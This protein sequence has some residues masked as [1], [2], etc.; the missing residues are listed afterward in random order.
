MRPNSILLCILFITADLFSTA[1]AQVNTTDSLALVDLY[2]STNGPNWTKHINWLTIAPVS[3]WYGVGVTNNRVTSLSL[4]ANRLNGKL[5]S[6]IGNLTGLQSLDLYANNLK[7][8][9]PSSVGNL[10]NLTYL[11]F[12]MNNLS[13]AIPS[14]IGNLINLT[15]LNFSTNNLAGAIPFSIGNLINLTYLDLT[16]KVTD[17]PRL[18]GVIP[19]SIGKLVKLIDLELSYNTLS[20]ELPSTFNKLVNLKRINL[21][22]NQLTQRS[23]VNIPDYPKNSYTVALQYNQFTFDGLEFI[24]EKYLFA[25]YDPQANTTIHQQG[26]V[27]SVYAGGTLSNNTYYWHKAGVDGSTQITGD[28]TFTPAESG[29]YYVNVTNSVVTQFNGAGG[30]ALILRSDTITYTAPLAVQKRVPVVKTNT[31][32]TH[33]SIYPN[34]ATN[35]LH[36]QTNGVAD[37]VITNSDGKVLL[38]RTINN[39]NVINISKYANGVY[40]IQNKTTGE[41]QKVI[42]AH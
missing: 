3:T 29:Q 34:P 41:M 27:L 22:H 24:A 40:Y 8:A 39:N 35:L 9:I 13:G 26:N 19:S 5:P 25:Q 36:I 7:G 21:Q 17:K 15:T 1:K 33:F 14:S 32:V 31:T 11:S 4:T 6:S 16:G 20:G 30:R 18:S 10:V 2:N 23:N 38:D 12:Y 28:S 42:V 37:I